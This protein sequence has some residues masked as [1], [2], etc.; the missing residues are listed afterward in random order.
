MSKE[1]REQIN[2]VKNFRQF[3]ESYSIH[4]NWL[5]LTDDEK[6]EMLFGKQSNLDKQFSEIMVKNLINDDTAEQWSTYNSAKIELENYDDI[7]NLEIK[8][9]ITDGE[10]AKKVI[11]SVIDK[12]KNKSKELIRLE[13]KIKTFN[14]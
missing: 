7:Y 8:Y 4:K 13:N 1:M 14:F 9:R 2:K 5:D 12:I 6:V 11:L 10:N 3:N